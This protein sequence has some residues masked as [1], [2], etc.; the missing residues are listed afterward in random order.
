MSRGPTATAR[1][2]TTI[3]FAIGASVFLLATAFVLAFAPGLVS[4]FTGSQPTAPLVANRVADDLVQHDLAVAGEPY[5]LRTPLNPALQAQ[6]LD[7]PGTLHANVTVTAG[8]SVVARRGP[9]PPSGASTA[10]AWRVVQYGGDRG[11]LAVRVW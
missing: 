2:Q 3:D 11:E 7:V 6:S 10:V 1:G 9:T 5:T 4:P 8:G